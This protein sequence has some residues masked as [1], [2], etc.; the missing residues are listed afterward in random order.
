MY[1]DLNEWINRSEQNRKLRRV[2]ELW[3][4]GK[5]RFPYEHESSYRF[6]DEQ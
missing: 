6:C 1:I 3:A 5:I 4:C 2:L